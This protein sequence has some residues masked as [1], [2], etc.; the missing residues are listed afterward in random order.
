MP[1]TAARPAAEGGWIELIV[2]RKTQV[3]EGIAHFDLRAADGGPL[4]A[5]TAG[6]H[7][8]LCL[9]GDLVRQY[10]LCGD[11]ARTDRYELGVLLEP[12]GRGGSRAAHEHLGPGSVVRVG[13]PRNLFGLVPGRHAL[14][15]AGGIGIT[16][17]LA[18]AEALN[19]ADR[20]FELHYC[21][22]SA[23][24][25]AF[26]ERIESAA[27]AGRAQCYLDDAPAARFDAQ[28]LIPAPEAGIHAYVCGPAGFL[29]HVLG[30]LRAKG[31]DEA[32]IHFERFS[33]APAEAEATGEADAAEAFE[34]QL[35][36]DGPV[37]PVGAGQSA[38][39]ALIAAGVP[40]PLSCEQGIC[41]TCAMRVL[42]GTPDHQD[43][44]FTDDEHAANDRFTPCCSRA[45]SRRLVVAPMD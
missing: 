28:T 35:G 40:V 18:M 3:A 5:F 30:T 8:D 9:P 15:I 12:D 20:S 6:A 42:E 41:G 2:H 25:M 29:D 13:A 17:I 44:Y 34:I 45:R 1:D 32:H 4:P 7:V 43:M 31:W 33:A 22:R 37:V 19:R 38:A 23:A 16:P 11:P 39:Q 26:R 24:R 10:S 14:L 36:V 21:A 27:W